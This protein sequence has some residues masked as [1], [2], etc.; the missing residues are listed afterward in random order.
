MPKLFQ[1][2]DLL[3]KVNY[4]ILKNRQKMEF[5]MIDLWL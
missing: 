5:M 4:K 1:I 3:D 2:N